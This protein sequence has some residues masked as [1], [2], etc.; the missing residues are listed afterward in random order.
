MLAFC[1]QQISR[2]ARFQESY[3]FIDTCEVKHKLFSWSTPL[4]HVGNVEG[5]ANECRDNTLVLLRLPPMRIIRV[6]A[7]IDMST[8]DWALLF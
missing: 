7:S 8:T 6:S 5:L 4:S 1:A 3:F 2:D